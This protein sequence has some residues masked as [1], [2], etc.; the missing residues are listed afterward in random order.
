V[1]L[2]ERGASS[3]RHPWEVQRFNAYRR[4]LGDHGALGARNVL[5]VGAGDGWFSDMLADVLPPDAVTVCWDV[6]YDEHDLEPARPG[7]VRTRERPAR[8]HD[9]VLLLDVLEHIEDP[10]AFIAESLVP[11]TE[12]GTPVLVAVPAYQR[13]FGAHDLALGHHR[14]YARRELLEQLAPWI[15]VREHGSLF[16]SLLL[17]RATMVAAERRRGPRA[18]EHGVGNWSGGSTVTAA[19]N[20]V[21]SVDARAGRAL[22]RAGIRLPGLSH[23]AFGVGR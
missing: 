2:T 12:L 20:G 6:N 21:L 4:I 1:D 13:L 22:G 19:V 9:L 17:P 11:I 18:V 15:D 16:S 3:D 10:D 23:W 5:D 14:R 8:G 7:Q